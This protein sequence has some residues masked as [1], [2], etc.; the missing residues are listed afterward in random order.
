MADRLVDFLVVGVQKGGTT[1][2]DWYLR[3]HP[4]ITMATRKEVH[5][6]DLDGNFAD[7]SQN[8]RDY[9]A[10]FSPGPATLCVGEVTPSYL[11]WEPVMRRVWDYRPDMKLIA[12]L[13]NPIDRAYSHWNMTR[14][15]GEESVPFLEA[16]RREPD[17]CREA[18]PDQHRIYS[19]VDRG[20]YVA[21]LRRMNRFF[22]ANQ[23]LVLRSDDL[24]SDPAAVVNRVVDFL[25]LDPVTD[26]RPRRAGTAVYEAPMDPEARNFLRETLFWEIREI[27]RVLGWDCAAWLGD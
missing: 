9:H 10:N 5:F 27:E 18:L 12:V 7:A 22:P 23:T 25:G 26:W 6:F 19:Y 2:L 16:I 13:R 8:Y 21:Q 24:R 17:R 3:Q 20:R 15:R 4:A 14:R 1:A 11:W